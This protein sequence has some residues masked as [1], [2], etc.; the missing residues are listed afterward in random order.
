MKNKNNF[1]LKLQ[2]MK[3]KFSKNCTIETIL[4]HLIYL[5]APF[6]YRFSFFFLNDLFLFTERKISNRY[7]LTLALME[8]LVKIQIKNFDS[9]FGIQFPK[10]S[11]AESRLPITDVLR[12]LNYS[13]T[14]GNLYLLCIITL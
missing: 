9:L 3:M 10:R 5:F 12:N 6:V 13:L 14:I 11:I 1:F 7:I 8:S 4:V 2:T